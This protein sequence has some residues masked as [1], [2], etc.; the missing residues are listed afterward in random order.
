MGLFSKGDYTAEYFLDYDSRLGVYCRF[1]SGYK[2]LV[3]KG[4]KISLDEYLDGKFSKQEPEAARIIRQRFIGELNEFIGEHGH[5]SA[6]DLAALAI[7]LSNEQMER[8]LDKARA[9]R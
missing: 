9:S 8:I 5:K 1:L 3:E 4:K 2:E 6:I 7:Q